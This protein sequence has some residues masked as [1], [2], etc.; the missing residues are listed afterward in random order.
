LA[1]VH[2]KRAEA[3]T[4]PRKNA[5]IHTKRAGQYALRSCFRAFDFRSPI[6]TILQLPLLPLS[7]DFIIPDNYPPSYPDKSNNESYFDSSVF[8]YLQD[9]SYNSNV[10]DA[11]VIF[12]K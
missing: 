6:S 3:P 4:S 2:Y 7:R 1:T 8:V 11:T 12:C 9:I 10:N 5:I